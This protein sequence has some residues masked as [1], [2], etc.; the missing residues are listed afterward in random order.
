[1]KK[2]WTGKEILRL[3]A[4]YPERST[5]LIAKSLNRTVSSVYQQARKLDLKKSPE[6]V[7]EEGRKN[8][9]H[10]KAVASRFKPEVKV[11]NKGLKGLQYEG[12]KPTQFKKGQS[13]HN[14]HPI[15]SYRIDKH[16][17][18]QQKISNATGSNS[19]RWR[20]VHELI[21]IAA[22]GPVPKGFLVVFKPGMKTS[23]VEEITLDRVECI[24]RVENMKR[25]TVHNYPP[26]IAR[27]IQLIGAVNRQINRRAKHEQ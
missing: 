25:N 24:S 3:L 13:P 16:G 20:S 7:R 12:S 10:P 2:P 27:T 15:G 26:E 5:A 22:H 19:M 18:L 9:Q 14:T 6:F 1:M 21:W 23:N 17:T 11:W 8:S 4:D